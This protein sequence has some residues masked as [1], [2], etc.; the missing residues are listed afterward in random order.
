MDGKRGEDVNNLDIHL[1]KNSEWG[2]VAYLSKSKYGKFGNSMYTKEEIVGAIT[3][4]Y[5]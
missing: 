5:K 3:Y 2:A 4:N 1:I